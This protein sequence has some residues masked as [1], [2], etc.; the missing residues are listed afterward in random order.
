[1]RLT[2]NELAREAAATGL[3]PHARRFGRSHQL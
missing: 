1:M 3:T 2:A